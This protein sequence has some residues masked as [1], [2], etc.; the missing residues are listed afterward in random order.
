IT[1]TRVY[2]R[3][4]LYPQAMKSIKI[5]EKRKLEEWEELR[6]LTASFNDSHGKNSRVLIRYSGTE[7]KL[8]VMIESEDEFVIHEY[9]SKFEELI[10]STIGI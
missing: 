2:E 7:P 1:P 5:R 6:G 8:R 9:M 3:L 10:K 4:R